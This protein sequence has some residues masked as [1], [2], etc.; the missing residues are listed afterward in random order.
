MV[1]V[2]ATTEAWWGETSALSRRRL[3]AGRC[4]E[5]SYVRV[6]ETAKMKIVAS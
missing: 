6:S 5:A 3:E 2:S 1:K 4:A